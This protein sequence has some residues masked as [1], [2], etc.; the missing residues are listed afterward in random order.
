MTRR[1]PGSIVIPL[2]VPAGPSL[3][4]TGAP[5]LIARSL[6]TVEEWTPAHPMPARCQAGQMSPRIVVLDQGQPIEFSFEDM[7]RYHGP[8]SPGGVAHAFKVLERA[9]PLLNPD[10]PCERREIAGCTAFGG[11][12]ARGGLGGGTR[13]GCEGR[14]VVGQSLPRAARGGAGVGFVFVLS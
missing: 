7:M 2:T 9:L 5:N 1:A 3:A 11:P 4:C 12:G 8:G 13:A 14:D 10:G 6:M